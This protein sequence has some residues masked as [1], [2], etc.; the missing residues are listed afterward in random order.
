ML[1]GCAEH[2]RD[3]VRYILCSSPPSGD[4]LSSAWI[5]F[6]CGV[7]L[8]TFLLSFAWCCFRTIT[9]HRRVVAAQT[10]EDP[11]VP[12]SPRT[13]PV[14]EISTRGGVVVCQPDASAVLGLLPN[15]DDAPTGPPPPRRQTMCRTRFFDWFSFNQP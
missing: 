13:P 1:E 2:L 14:V 5:T 12:P 6:V 8:G 7:F 10:Q 4:E 11:E 3:G 9:L 15:C